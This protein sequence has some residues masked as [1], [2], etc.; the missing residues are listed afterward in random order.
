MRMNSF[1]STQR[2]EDTIIDFT[3]TMLQDAPYLISCNPFDRSDPK[4]EYNF[5]RKAIPDKYG[6]SSD[7]QKEYLKQMF[8]NLKRGNFHLSRGE[9]DRGCNFIIEASYLVPFVEGFERWENYYY[10]ALKDIKNREELTQLSSELFKNYWENY[11]DLF[12]HLLEEPVEN[13]EISFDK[14]YSEY[15]EILEYMYSQLTLK[16]N[17]SILEYDHIFESDDSC[18]VVYTKNFSD[19]RMGF[20]ELCSAVPA[21]LD[22]VHVQLEEHEHKSPVSYSEEDI[23]ELLLKNSFSAGA[24][25]THMVDSYCTFTVSQGKIKYKSGRNFTLIWCK[26]EINEYEFYFHHDYRS[27]STFFDK[28]TSRRLTMF[29]NMNWVPKQVKWDFILKK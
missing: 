24:T 13:E 11:K 3:D 20:T 25:G 22:V 7:K 8:L 12:V 5:Y 4:W 27:S 2:Q 15:Q 19:W 17:R 29:N 1:N 14:L 18:V 10:R 26:N 9:Q 16:F 28:K 6:L 23:I 21:V